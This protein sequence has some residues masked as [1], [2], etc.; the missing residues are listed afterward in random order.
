MSSISNTILAPGIYH[1]KGYQDG[2][3]QGKKL[4][5]SAEQAMSDVRKQSLANSLGVIG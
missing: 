2:F 3:W 1:Q 4:L 5:L